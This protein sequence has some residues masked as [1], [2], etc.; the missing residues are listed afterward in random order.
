[1]MHKGL[2]PFC[3]V[4]SFCSV[5]WLASM[6]LSLSERGTGWDSPILLALSPQNCSC[7][8]TLNKS[9]WLTA[10]V[11]FW[12]QLSPLLFWFILHSS[13]GFIF[14]SGLLFILFPVH[15]P[16]P[17]P[18]A[19][20]MKYSFLACDPL[21]SP[22][23]WI[24]DPEAPELSGRPTWDITNNEMYVGKVEDPVPA[25][26]PSSLSQHWKLVV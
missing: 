13:R 14:P 4:I 12:P 11:L 26:I 7:F 15:R 9:P 25:Y 17:H 2:L 16:L 21:I 18:T 5:V 3:L 24:V 23:P 10:A 8:R 20:R 22:K 1:M 6:W 19:S